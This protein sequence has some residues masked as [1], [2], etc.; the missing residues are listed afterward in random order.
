MKLIFIYGTL[1]RGFNRHS[2]L[3]DQRY[4]G[5]A[6]SASRYSI[7]HISGFPALV[8]DSQNPKE[9]WGELYEVD[10]E[11]L[12]K[13]DEIES[14]SNNLFQ[15]RTVVLARYNLVNLPITKEVFEDLHKNIA[16]AYFFQKDVSG[17]RDCGHCWTLR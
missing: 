8:E 2:A 4:L 9:I 14:I 13:L 3:V 16:D 17:A 12:R 1:K 5:T 10:N 11:C 7:F 15:R 6:F